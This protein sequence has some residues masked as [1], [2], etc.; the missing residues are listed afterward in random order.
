MKKKPTVLTH[1]YYQES[2]QQKTYVKYR[3]AGTQIDISRLTKQQSYWRKNEYG[4][5]TWEKKRIV[6]SHWEACY[7]QENFK[8][9]MIAFIQHLITSSFELFVLDEKGQLISVSSTKEICRHLTARLIEP[10]SQMRERLSQTL[11]TTNNDGV[12][13]SHYVCLDS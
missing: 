1:F 4:V 7:N 8:E 2:S 5:D 6:I 13:L 12:P 11:Q 10:A 3:E 9:K